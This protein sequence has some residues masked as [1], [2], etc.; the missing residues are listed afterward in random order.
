MG[1]ETLE[2]ILGQGELEFEFTVR[3]HSGTA[4]GHSKITHPIEVV[5]PNPRDHRE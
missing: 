3:E 2:I 5:A 1:N 4:D